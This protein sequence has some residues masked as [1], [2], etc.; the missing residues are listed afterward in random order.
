MTEQ[1][2]KLRYGWTTGACATAAS[3]AAYCALLTGKFPDPVQI[4]LPKGQTPEFFLV[5]KEQTADFARA[6]VRKN[7]GDDPDVTHGALVTADVR[8]GNAGCGVQ[9]Q[10]GEGVGT[11]TLPGLTL[12]VGEAAINPVPRRMMTQEITKLANR[13][14]KN[15]DVIIN[16]SVKGGREI[17]KKT[18]NSRLGIVGGIS[19]LGTTGIVVPYS[20]SAWISAI[21]RGID[22]ARACGIKHLMPCVGSTS[23]SMVRTFYSPAS[24]AIIDMGDFV[25]GTLKYLRKNPF[26]MVSIAG[27]FAK[28]TKLA[29]GARDLHSK[30]SQV[31]KKFL[32]N[33]LNELGASGVLVQKAKSANTALEILNLASAEGVPLA[34]AIADRA[35]EVAIEILRHE[36]VKIEVLVCNREGELIGRSTATY[37]Q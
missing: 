3:K 23:E 21:H 15:C 2:A 27:G 10:A 18:L 24:E 5:E 32:A 25:G 13:Y 14:G 11:V 33:V 19:I 30:R 6:S 16:I 4:T 12:A 9:F 29:N 1:K 37:P 22:V 31:D 8:V 17:A 20:C 34:N 28:M 36:D 26:P 7:A 35:C